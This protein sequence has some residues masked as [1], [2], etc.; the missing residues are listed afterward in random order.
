MRVR[1]TGKVIE[2]GAGTEEFSSKLKRNRPIKQLQ[3]N[4]LRSAVYHDL[5]EIKFIRLQKALGFLCILLGFGVIAAIGAQ[6]P[7]A[8]QGA[9]A[10]TAGICAA[11]LAF[12]F[13][14]RARDH[15]KLQGRFRTLLEK[16]Y[17]DCDV[18]AM[19][20][21]FERISASAPP[22]SK[23]TNRKAHYIAGETLYGERFAGN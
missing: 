17:P 18:D 22:M 11:Q 23:R 4:L 1:S 9:G 13:G 7:L 8:G 15:E 5:Q 21:D 6:Y 20:S 16:T 2:I 14:G 3:F 19:T 10:A 12:D